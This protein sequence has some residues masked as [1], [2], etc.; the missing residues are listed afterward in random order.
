[1][2]FFFFFCFK[3]YF[4][5][6]VFILIKTKKKSSLVVLEG[7]ALVTLAVATS[8][9]SFGTAG[10]DVGLGVLARATGSTEVLLGLAAGVLATEEVGV[11]AGGGDSGELIEGD[12]FTA[13]T[14]DA[15]AGFAGEAEGADA[16]LAELVEADII[17]D[18]TDDDGDGGLSLGRVLPDG[19]ALQDDGEAGEGDGSAVA[20][21][22]EEALVDGLVEGRL[23]ASGQELVE[24]DEELDVRVGGVGGAT[25]EVLGLLNTVDIN[26]HCF[27]LIVNFVF[28]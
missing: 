25:N 21:A 17:E 1:V 24:L 27:L 18:V 23:G 20:T 3:N 16:E 28:F 5:F 22:L 7:L 14:L 10:R 4:F 15:L 6:F 11:L 8:A 26:T 2:F 13:G 19:L 12:A 9:G